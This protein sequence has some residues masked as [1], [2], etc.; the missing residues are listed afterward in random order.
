MPTATDDT[1]STNAVLTL[2]RGI[3]EDLRGMR[4][5]VRTAIRRLDQH[6]TQRD[7]QATTIARIE[8]M[9]ESI[10]EKAEKNAKECTA[11]LSAQKVKIAGMIGWAMGAGAVTAMIVEGVIAFLKH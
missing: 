6:D 3:D 4:D 8:R 11:E 1:G 2:L 10:G 5:E 7:A 9:C